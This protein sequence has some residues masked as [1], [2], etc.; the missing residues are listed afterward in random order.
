M[1][2][3]I[4]QPER[5]L[6]ELQAQLFEQLAVEYTNYKAV[7]LLNRIPLEGRVAI[8]MSFMVAPYVIRAIRRWRKGE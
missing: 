4:P 6:P 7:E 5:Q 2:S 8:T 1:F 3:L